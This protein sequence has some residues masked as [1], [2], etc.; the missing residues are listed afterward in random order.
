VN[1][2]PTVE[3]LDRSTPFHAALV[4]GGGGASGEAFTDG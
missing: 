1:A 3:A 4:I 2:E